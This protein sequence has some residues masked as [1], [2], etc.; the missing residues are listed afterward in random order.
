MPMVHDKE[1][2]SIIE[3]LQLMDDN[4]Q[5]KIVKEQIYKEVRLLVEEL[6]YEQKK[7]SF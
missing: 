4:V 6:P 5:D 3:S 7:L 1:D 2:Y